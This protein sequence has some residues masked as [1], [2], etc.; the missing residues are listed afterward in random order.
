MQPCLRWPL[1]STGTHASTQTVCS[2]TIRTPTG[3]ASLTGVIALAGLQP[4]LTSPP[5]A[6]LRPCHHICWP[7]FWLQEGTVPLLMAVQV[8]P[9]QILGAASVHRHGCEGHAA[10]CVLPSQLTTELFLGECEQSSTSSALQSQ[11]PSTVP[12]ALLLA[13]RL[14]SA[15]LPA[16]A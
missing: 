15:L 2:T 9:G 13:S 4:P 6:C 12:R 16:A 14:M 11:G 7:H 3:S 10:C 8:H 5:K 1:V